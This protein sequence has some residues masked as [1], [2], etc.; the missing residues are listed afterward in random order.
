VEAVRDNPER[1]ATEVRSFLA[2]YADRAKRQALDTAAAVQGR[3][4]KGSWITFAVMAVT[5]MVSILGAVSGVPSWQQWRL[6]LFQRQA[7]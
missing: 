6:R 1:V 2:R 3:A 5:F 4:T 7:V